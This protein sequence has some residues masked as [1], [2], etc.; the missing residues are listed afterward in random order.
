VNPEKTPKYITYRFSF[1]EKVLGAFQGLRLRFFPRRILIA[2]PYV[3]EFG[4]ELMEWQACVRAL[5]PKYDEVHVLAYPGRDFLYPNCRVHHHSIKL[6]SAGYKHGRFSPYEL[7]CIARA[8]AS[9]LGLM[10]YDLMGILNTC[11]KYHR[12][13]ILRSRFEP[14]FPNERVGTPNFDVAF[15]FRQVDK[16]GPDKSRNY[17]EAWC[18]R[19][20]ELCSKA[21]LKMCCIGHPNYSYCPDGIEDLRC[22]DLHSSVKTLGNSRILVGELSGPI[23]L[24]Q[25]CGCPVLFWAPDQ[26]RIDNCNRWN[27]FNVPT[28]VAGNDMPPP[29]PESV[30]QMIEST[31]KTL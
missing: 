18:E 31:L 1:L 20:A 17:P 3:G 5:V 6:E 12:K 16:D 15:H 19:L 26:W 9:E 28:F 11:T 13:Y 24:A 27:I 22:E 29:K 21:K 10:N 7:E 23:H 25:L 2:G 14:L 4:H 8:K 30:F